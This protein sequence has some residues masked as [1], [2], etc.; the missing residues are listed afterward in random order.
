MVR[1]GLVGHISELIVANAVL[2]GKGAFDGRFAVWDRV[3]ATLLPTMT[4]LDPVLPASFLF[5]DLEDRSV[6]LTAP[7]SPQLPS[8]P[9]ASSP[10]AMS[11]RTR[12]RRTG[13]LMP[14]ATVSVLHKSTSNYRRRL[15]AGA[16]GVV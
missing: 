13:Q 5:E 11:H 15:P 6:R 4:D 10:T 2:L 8:A 1:F 16:R 12:F 14:L 9:C 7:P 3:F